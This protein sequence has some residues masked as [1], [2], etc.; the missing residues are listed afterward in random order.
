MSQLSEIFFFNLFFPNLIFCYWEE[1]SVKSLIKSSRRWEERPLKE[2]EERECV[3]P[4]SISA[5]TKKVRVTEREEEEGGGGGGGGGGGLCASDP[6]KPQP[7]IICHSLFQ[8]QSLDPSIWSQLEPPCVTT[9]THTHTHTHSLGL[10]ADSW[11]NEDAVKTTERWVKTHTHTHREMS[12]PPLRLQL[13]S[14]SVRVKWAGTSFYF[15][16]LLL[17]R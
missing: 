5:V 8:A 7:L 1:L 14:L 17:T 6:S 2:L 4:R 12:S 3:C 15:W 9:E 13:S 11:E 10:T 16:L